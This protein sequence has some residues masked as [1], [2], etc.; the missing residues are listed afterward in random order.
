M[1]KEENTQ[2]SQFKKYINNKLLKL[3][4]IKKFNFIKFISIINFYYISKWRKNIRN[5]S[6]EECEGNIIEA[7]NQLEINKL[8]ISLPFKKAFESTILSMKNPI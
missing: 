6:D 5:S 7:N 3:N 2:N 8:V 1:S 4:N